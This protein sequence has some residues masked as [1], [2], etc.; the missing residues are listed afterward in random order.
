MKNNYRN[1]FIDVTGLVIRYDSDLIP[2]ILPAD[3]R[4]YRDAYIASENDSQHYGYGF[5]SEFFD[6]KSMW[7]DFR[8][9]ITWKKKQ[10][11][12]QAEDNRVFAVVREDN[13]SLIEV[14]RS[15]QAAEAVSS[16]L[17]VPT[18]VELFVLTK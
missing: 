13:N 15:K 1:Q 5:W 8:N 17:R 9:F 6:E 7:D 2:G 3:V 12:R 10:K 11:A 4:E 16:A 18:R 14:C